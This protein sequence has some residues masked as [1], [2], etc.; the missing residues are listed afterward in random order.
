MSFIKNGDPT[1]IIEFY[2][3]EKPQVCKKCGKLL[4]IIA[5]KEDSV[6]II[7]DCDLEED[8]GGVDHA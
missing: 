4:K 5:L 3:E 2:K 8:E 1:P 7:C 6:D